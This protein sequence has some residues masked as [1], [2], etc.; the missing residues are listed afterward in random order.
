MDI[1]SCLTYIPTNMQ[2]VEEAWKDKKRRKIGNV[3]T[4]FNG[5]LFCEK[6]LKENSFSWQ[7]LRSEGYFWRGWYQPVL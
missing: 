2:C 6:V 3:F 7:K 1:F 4:T 5:E